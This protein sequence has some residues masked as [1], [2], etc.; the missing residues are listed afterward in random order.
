[1]QKVAADIPNALKTVAEVSVA[2]A[3]HVDTAAYTHPD[4]AVAAGEDGDAVNEVAAISSLPAVAAE[5]LCAAVE[6]DEGAPGLTK[7]QG[8]FQV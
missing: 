3:L 1:M 8:R 7:P 2:A 4:A 6:A 5:E